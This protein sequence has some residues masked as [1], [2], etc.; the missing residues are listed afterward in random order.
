M[1]Q[2]TPPPSSLVV[3]KVWPCLLFF[4]RRSP[5]KLYEGRPPTASPM[6]RRVLSYS[7]PPLLA[8]VCRRCEHDP[9]TTGWGNP[10]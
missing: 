10:Q 9:P 5:P 3:S 6:M 2:M 8:E 4:A 7:F 1:R